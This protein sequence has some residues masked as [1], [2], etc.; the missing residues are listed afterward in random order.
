MWLLILITLAVNGDNG[1][2]SNVHTLSFPNAITCEKAAS[3]F[4]KVSMSV[5]GSNGAKLVITAKCVQTGS[6]G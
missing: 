1:V 3:V 2:H 4:E 5:P 6:R